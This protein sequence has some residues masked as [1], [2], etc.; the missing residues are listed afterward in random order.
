MEFIFDLLAEIIMEP[1][2]EGYLLAMTY[3]TDGSKKLNEDKVRT[4][5]ILESIALFLM[6]VVGGIKLAESGGA[7][8]TG[9]VLF[10]SSVAVSVVQISLGIILN[11]LKK[12]NNIN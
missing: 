4:F 8:V 12:K 7:S 3:F 10:I 1:I 2:I 6:F 11:R 9:K 5:V